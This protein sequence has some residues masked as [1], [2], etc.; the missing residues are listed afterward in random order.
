MAGR[1]S[2]FRPGPAAPINVLLE[3]GSA[4]VSG[5]TLAL[6]DSQL[7][8]GRWFHRWSG[9]VEA[10]QPAHLTLPRVGRAPRLLLAGL[11]G[12]L[13]LILALAGWRVAARGA[14]PEGAPTPDRLLESLAELD[15]RYAGREAE[16]PSG[17][18]DQYR[19][20]RARL[21]RALEEALAGAGAGQ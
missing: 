6:A 12:G 1:R 5:G 3:E 2:I 13:A 4:R 10:G 16:V 20:E 17:E 7:I 11:V 21:K 8:E 19:V 15:A 18:W 9:R 14:S